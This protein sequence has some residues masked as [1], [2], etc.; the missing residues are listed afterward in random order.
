MTIARLVGLGPLILMLS[1][2][3]S[4]PAIPVAERVDLDR[5]MGDYPDGHSA[6]IGSVVGWYHDGSI[7]LPVND[8][9]LYIGVL[10]APK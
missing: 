1:A 9:Q 8:G 3:S 2:C 4:S 10:P 5:F 7:L 6:Q